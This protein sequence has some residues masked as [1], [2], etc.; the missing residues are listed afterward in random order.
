MLYLRWYYYSGKT[1]VFTVVS[2][3]HGGGN[4]WGETKAVIEDTQE[5]PEQVFEE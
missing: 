4:G 3:Y 5:A 1:A 2:Y